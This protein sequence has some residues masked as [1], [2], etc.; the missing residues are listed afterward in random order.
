MNG[1]KVQ[2]LRAPAVIAASAALLAVIA[3][4]GSAGAQSTGS[5]TAS[6][7]R[8]VLLQANANATDVAR[9]TLITQIQVDGEGELSFAVPTVDGAA[10]R[11]MDSFGGPTVEGDSASYTVEVDGPDTVRTS[12]AFDPEDVPVELEIT[13]TLDG[14]RIDLTDLKNATGDVELSYTAKNVTSTPTTLQYQD[15]SGATITEEI[16]LPTAMGGTLEIIFPPT[17]A[18]VESEDATVVSG[19]GT[20]STQVNASW[21]LFEP[22]GEPEG[23]ITIK[24]RVTDGDMPPANLKFT[25]LQ[26]VENPTARA[27]SGQLAGGAATGT[28]IYEG[29]KALEEGASTLQTGLGEAAAGAEEIAAGVEN[30]LV[31]GVNELN[32]GVQDSLVPGVNQLVAALR[33]LPGTVAGSADFQ[34][35]TGGFAALD[36]AVGGVRDAL[37]AWT[38]TGT[39]AGQYLTADGDIDKSRTTVARTLW[40]LIY[41]VRAADVPAGSASAVPAED[42]GGLSNPDCNLANP[43]DPANPC[44]AWQVVQLVKGG[45][46]QVSGGLGTA[47]GA[48]DGQINPGLQQIQA[49][50]TGAQTA[51]DAQLN[52]GV[53]QIAGG[54]TQAQSALTG[55]GAGAWG[56]LA[57]VLGCQTAPAGTLNGNTGPIV[58]AC[59][60]PITSVAGDVTA[61]VAALLQALS[62]GLYAGPNADPAQSGLAALLGQLA[63][64]Q[65]LGAVSGGLT[66]ISTGLS[67]AI[68]GLGQASGGLTQ[69]SAG[70]GGASGAL[71]QQLSDALT[72]LQ[73]S[74]TTDPTGIPDPNTAKDTTATGILNELRAALTLG[75]VGDSG[76]PGQCAGYAT[77]GNPASGLN[78]SVTPEQIAATCAAADVLNIALLISGQIETGVSQT[79]LSGISDQLVA[80]VQPLAAGVGTLAA[81]TQQ[82]ADGVAPLAAGTRQ[83][84]D[85][86]PAAYDGAGQ[87]ITEGAQPLQESGNDATLNYARQVAL[88]DAMN[89]QELVDSYIPGGPAQGDEVVTNGVYSFELAG[90]GGGTRTGVNFGLAAL[91]L[92]GAVGAGAVLGSRRGG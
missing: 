27:L 54:L 73:L 3:L 41:G 56:Q 17:W 65:G 33:N 67:Q 2:S 34:Q 5:P 44:G 63:G 82:L 14:Q 23:T 19:D 68:P 43:K 91:A 69:V 36:G 45:M 53:Q 74:V 75:G 37:G 64:A 61:N 57:A 77:P 4:P 6:V 62:G 51:I 8:A 66:Q 11:N 78:P 52:P 20:G 87:I 79:L 39:N 48:I 49:G 81:G 15:A 83:L 18:R 32:D 47:K 1:Q 26:P 71:D 76:V 89:D 58:V 16:D 90:T 30:T 12:Q 84:A 59:P 31:P 28:S 85:G 29:G 92:I 70:L 50:L 86:L 35:L 7:T 88:Y 10:P 22:F 46:G 13:A 55:P 60:T 40:G 21:T 38:P 24:A 42:T 25:V 9:A 80:G 72:Q